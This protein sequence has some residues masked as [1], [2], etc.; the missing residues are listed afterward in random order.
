MERARQRVY[1][2]S[3]IWFVVTFVFV[4]C[5]PSSLRSTHTPFNH[6]AQLAHAWIHGHL[7]LVHGAPAYA[8]GN[9]FALFQG[10]TYVSFP[11]VPA[12]LLVPF[13][14][15]SGSPEGVRDGLIFVA[16]SGVAPA[17]LFL[18]LERLVEQGKSSRSVRENAAFALLFAFGTVYWFSSL[19]GT[20]WFAAHVLGAALAATYLF[21][22][23]GAQNPTVAGIALGLAIGTRTTIG[24][25]I[26][27]FAWELRSEFV[28]Q[29]M[30]R[31]NVLRK[32]LF[33]VLPLA[34]IVGLLMW[35]NLARFGDPLEFGH[36]HLA[37]VWR[38]RIDTWGLFSLHYL[39]R[40]LAVAF[41]SLPFS[42]T[43]D[44]PFRINAHGLA[45]WFTSPFL[46]WAAWP[47]QLGVGQ[48]ETYRALLAATLAVFG[49]N[50]LYQNTGWIQFGYRFS[51]DFVIFVMAMLAIRRGPLRPSFSL[52]AAVAVLINAFGA[53]TFQRAGY[54]RFYL[55]E[56]TQTVIF[57][58]D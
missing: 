10:K 42:G 7:D 39:G 15:L 46:V 29:R 24:L 2:A 13:V 23:L 21:A 44:A 19:Q 45:L 1:V 4:I 56:P 47:G 6:F 18:A 34:A 28:Q 58:P 57:E 33:F 41:A 36:R 17:M 52:C 35:H 49:L 43:A 30:P 8:Q 26:L 25:S 55:T 53:L 54:E 12:V 27:L 22:S 51:N 48:R 16:L 40:N 32:A 37:I 20:V 11:P 3:A 38:D 9:D 14:W 31:A 50:L 5:A